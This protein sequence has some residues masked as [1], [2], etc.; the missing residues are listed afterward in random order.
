LPAILFGSISTI[1]DT[2][3][4]QRESFNEAF[5]THGIDWNWSRDEYLPLLQSN[6]GAQRIADYASAQGEDI[7]AA[8]VHQTKSEVFQRKLSEARATARP[9]VVET[10]QAA[11]ADGVK[12]AL[13]TTTAR[14]NVTALLDGVD[15]L[16][17]TDFDLITDASSVEA[18][19]P[20]PAVYAHALDD[21]GEH[22]T[23]AVAIEDN[24]GGVQ[25]AQAAG[26]RT[27]AFP[28]QNTAGHDFDAA[29]ERVERLD[30]EEV[31][32]LIAAA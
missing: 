29:D 2:S 21:L 30:A 15:G 23:A 16:A 25:S 20:D 32:A 5:Q 14:E 26:L 31:R 11:R 27:I 22:A 9:G 1:A 28:N 6:G 18:S 7:D 17:A 3:E 19:K 13:V 4:L 10:I 24:L 12:V 8:A